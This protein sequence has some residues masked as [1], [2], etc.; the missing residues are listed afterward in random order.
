MTSASVKNA[1]AMNTSVP[2]MPRRASSLIT[3]SRRWV[4]LAN[5]L[6]MSGSSREALFHAEPPG[7]GH[8]ASVTPSSDADASHEA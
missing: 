1:T 2:L 6:S 3:K 7:R 8:R 4:R 5:T